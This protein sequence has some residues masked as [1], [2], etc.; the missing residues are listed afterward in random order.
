MRDEA[1]E[2]I[3]AMVA[4]AMTK[5]VEH[6]RPVDPWNHYDSAFFLLRMEQEM[7]EVFGAWDDGDREDLMD[8]L[9][10]VANF[11]M[12]LWIQKKMQKSGTWTSKT[13][14]ID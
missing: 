3:E 10:D 7:K 4:K 9:I 13:Q 14:E 11:A 6:D 1:E 2:F 5:V 8:E 12:F